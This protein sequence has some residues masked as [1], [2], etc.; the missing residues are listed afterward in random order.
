MLGNKINASLIFKMRLFLSFLELVPEA[1][2]DLSERTTSI[3][4]EVM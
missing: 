3:E 4:M 1:N 2:V